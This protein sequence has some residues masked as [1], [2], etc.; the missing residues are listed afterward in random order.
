MRFTFGGRDPGDEDGPAATRLNDWTPERDARL[1]AAAL[2]E[3]Q[4]RITIGLMMID[5]T[6][7]ALDRLALERLTL[8]IPDLSDQGLAWL[9]FYR[10]LV[11]TGRLGDHMRGTDEPSAGLPDRR[12]AGHR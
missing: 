8:A 9:R 11:M 6:A 12:A 4:G 2:P 7:A 10:W 1:V 5:D 3:R